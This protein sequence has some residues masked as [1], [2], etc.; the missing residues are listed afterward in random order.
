ML[1]SWVVNDIPLYISMSHAEELVENVTQYHTYWRSLYPKLHLHIEQE[2]RSQFEHYNILLSRIPSTTTHLIFTDDDDLWHSKRTLKVRTTP[3]QDILR[4]H[5]IDYEDGKISE[6]IYSE[7][8]D[9]CV[10]VNVL[11]DFL[12]YTHNRH[13][14][15]ADACFVKYIESRH[16]VTEIMKGWYYVYRRHVRSVIICP[17]SYQCLLDDL[18]SGSLHLVVVATAANALSSDEFVNDFLREFYR[19]NTLTRDMWME[20]KV[21]RC[22]KSLLDESEELQKLVHG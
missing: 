17:N 15:Y 12:Y 9:Y 14:L 8:W 7:H 20:T 19:F 11:R 6:S 5:H 4:L 21:R 1:Q 18:T 2:K 16:H 10:P 13:H 3:F 22:L